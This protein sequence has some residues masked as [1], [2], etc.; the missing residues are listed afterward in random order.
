MPTHRG[1]V[2]VQLDLRPTFGA[3]LSCDL[4]QLSPLRGR[5]SFRSRI[6]A[7]PRDQHL[8]APSL[9]GQLTD[10]MA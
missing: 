1:V 5:L 6:L 4:R 10:A 9:L 2:F 8:I 7:N 3:P